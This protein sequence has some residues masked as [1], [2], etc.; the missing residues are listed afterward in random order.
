MPV[1]VL[2]A[3][4]VA[5]A[6]AVAVAVGGMFTVDVGVPVGGATAVPVAVGSAAGQALVL[7]LIQH[8]S[9]HDSGAPGRRHDLEHSF[10]LS[11]DRL[12]PRDPTSD[13]RWRFASCCW[14]P[15]RPPR[16]R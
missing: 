11:Y 4:L 5:V 16:R 8:R 2:V 9:L 15:A 1:G 7:A 14:V 12:D 6:A 3:V 10:A 13:G